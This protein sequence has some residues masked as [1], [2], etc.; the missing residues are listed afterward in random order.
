[1]RLFLYFFFNKW[2]SIVVNTRSSL[3]CLERLS[4]PVLIF[5]LLPDLP[6]LLFQRF[7]SF[8]S[9]LTFSSLER[10]LFSLGELGTPNESFDVL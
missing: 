4:N 5:F 8:V 7:P 6:C 1:M 2:F 3:V 10:D 9:V